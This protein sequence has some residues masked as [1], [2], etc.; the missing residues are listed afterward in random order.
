LPKGNH[1]VLARLPT[2]GAGGVA[3]H[4]QDP[5]LPGADSHGGLSAREANACI[6]EE[7]T[8]VLGLSNDGNDIKPSIFNDDGE[9]LDLTWQDELFLRVLYDPRVHA[10]MNRAEFTALATQIID[11]QRPVAAMA[12]KPMP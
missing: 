1:H 3:A 11:S 2:T 6:V 5:I 8:Q 12:Q 10:G 4:T 9:Y 7:I